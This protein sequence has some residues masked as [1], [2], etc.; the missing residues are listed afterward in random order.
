MLEASK[1]QSKIPVNSYQM[2]SFHE[3]QIDAWK[4]QPEEYDD[5]S[6]QK[7]IKGWVWKEINCFDPILFQI[8]YIYEKLKNFSE[9]GARNRED[10]Q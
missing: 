8:D 6:L 2:G 4:I 7:T 10:D 3:E 9:K 1:N 5:F